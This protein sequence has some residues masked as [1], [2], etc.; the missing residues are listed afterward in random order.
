[1][2]VERAQ[3][4]SSGFSLRRAGEAWAPIIFERAW[5]RT[6]RRLKAG[7]R[8][9]AL[10]LLLALCESIAHGAP[11][12]GLLQL[13][14]GTSLHGAL[15]GI[16]TQNGVA[17]SFPAARGPLALRPDNISTI[18]FDTVVAATNRAT[19]PTCR[20]RFHNGDEIL[21]DLVG[22]N[23][24]TATIR[25]SFG[26]ELKSPKEAFSSLQFSSHGFKVLYEGPNSAD[27]WK[28]GR[29]GHGWTYK[30]G[31]LIANGADILGR[32]FGLTNSSSLEFDLAWSGAFSLTVTVYAQTIERFDYST[33]AYVFYFNPG[34]VSI[35]R[36]QAGAGAMMLGRGDIPDMVTRN[37]GRFEIRSNRE[38]ATLSLFVNGA[39]V[40]RWK[41]PRGFVSSGSGIVFYSQ[42]ESP[43]LKLSNI[44]LSEWDGRFEPEVTSTNKLTEDVVYLANKDKVVGKVEGFGEDKLRVQTHA[45]ALD[46]PLSRVTEVYFANAQLPSTKTSPW[47]VRASFPG[48]ETVSFLL[49]KWSA[50]EVTGMSGNFGPVAFNPRAI[51]SLQFNSERAD[52]KSNE[53]G[54]D[55]WIPDL[56]D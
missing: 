34:G 23:G 18:R 20:F 15:D 39:L 51:R 3:V 30:D 52:I 12:S 26:G 36:I 19:R 9:F 10:T 31:T 44:K 28:T 8:T 35:Q 21:G 48:G 13:F 37:R 22:I 56:N 33:S 46:I 40:Q 14:D 53:T 25:S 49:D 11:A 5:L 50:G 45:T 1:M 54:D 4:C 47:S 32:D 43:T 17:W 27:E 24:D 42:V 29:T 41:D 7:L 16:S 6:S 38:E 2:N 55:D